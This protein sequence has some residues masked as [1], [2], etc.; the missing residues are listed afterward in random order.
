MTAKEERKKGSDEARTPGSA[1]VPNISADTYV[2]SEEETRR[3]D[4]R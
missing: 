4:L 3:K 1:G 2:K